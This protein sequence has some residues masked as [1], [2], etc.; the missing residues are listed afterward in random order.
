V[1]D[2]KKTLIAYRLQR[3][4][5]TLEEARLLLDAGHVNTCVNRL[6]Y[7]CFYAV[8]ALLMTRNV[9]TSKH[10]HLRSLLHRD[11]VKPGHIPAEMG[12]HFDLLFDSRQEGDYAD[13]VV[14]D[15]RDVEPW[16]ERTESFVDYVAQLVARAI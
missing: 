12:E 9:S 14:F 2:H 11:Y 7:A 15:A 13:L 6:Y 16:L 10:T 3:A 4:R 5:E 1:N 8:S